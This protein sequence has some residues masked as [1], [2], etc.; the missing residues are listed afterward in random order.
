M[1]LRGRRGR[2]KG[3]GRGE[4]GEGG[5]GGRGERGEGGERGGREGKR[6]G[7]R[8]GWGEGEKG[9]ERRMERGERGRGRGRRSTDSSGI[10]I[11]SALCLRLLPPTGQRG[12]RGESR[13]GEGERGRGGRTEVHAVLHGWHSINSHPKGESPNSWEKIPSENIPAHMRTHGHSVDHMTIT[14]HTQ[15]VTC[16][17]HWYMHVHMKNSH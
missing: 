15:D 13:G 5:R 3:E 9:G 17:Q 7:G 12:E 8:G 1:T 16:L 4:R 11:V 6:G 2:S 14:C 10:P